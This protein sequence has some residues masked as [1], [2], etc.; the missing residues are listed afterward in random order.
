MSEKMSQ[1]GVFYC[2]MSVLTLP[3]INQ[4]TKSEFTRIISQLLRK[5]QSTHI[6]KRKTTV[7]LFV[8]DLYHK[9]VNEN[10]KLPVVN[11]QGL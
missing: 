7:Y 11:S 5:A 9:I 1:V 6:S 3:A 2:N 10:Q 8:N 4:K